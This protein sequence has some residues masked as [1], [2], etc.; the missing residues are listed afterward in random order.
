MAAHEG[1]VDV[2]KILIK[3][4]DQINVLTKVCKV[5]NK[6]FLTLSLWFVLILLL[7]AKE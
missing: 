1:R 6:F 4:Q 2:V 5:T 3:V 7:N